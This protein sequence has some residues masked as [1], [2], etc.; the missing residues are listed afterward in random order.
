MET[1]LFTSTC[2]RGEN[3][4]CVTTEALCHSTRGQGARS[5]EEV[6]AS[7]SQVLPSLRAGKVG[8]PY[9]NRVQSDV[10]AIK[11]EMEKSTFIQTRPHGQCNRF[12]RI[13]ENGTNSHA[14]AYVTVFEWI[15][16]GGG[17]TPRTG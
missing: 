1:Y 7:T 12:T 13:W 5:R 2:A 8:S 3:S 14:S 10:D 15:W 9:R 4:I 6:C 11:T 17:F 16:K